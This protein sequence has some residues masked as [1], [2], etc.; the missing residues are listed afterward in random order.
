MG[1][2]DCGKI[3][4]CHCLKHL[5]LGAQSSL[6]L[7]LKKEKS[8]RYMYLN[9]HISILQYTVFRKKVVYFVFEHNFT[10]TGS[11]FLQF[12]VTTTE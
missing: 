1:S 11:I 12:S 6:T 7:E 4:K 8:P 9:K 5:C 2:K 10:T 3:N